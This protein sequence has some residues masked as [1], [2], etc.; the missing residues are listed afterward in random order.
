MP[1]C[2]KIQ[3]HLHRVVVYFLLFAKVIGGNRRILQSLFQQ[4]LEQRLF[5]ICA[6]S[7]QLRLQEPGS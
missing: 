5:G 1:P 4:D 7:H 2:N 6:A 3:S